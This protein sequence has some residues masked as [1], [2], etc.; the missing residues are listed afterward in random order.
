MPRGQRFWAGANAPFLAEKRQER[1]FMAKTAVFRA[2]TQE[3]GGA[4]ARSDSPEL[5][6]RLCDATRPLL[7]RVKGSKV[8]ISG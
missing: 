8:V 7:A 5:L 2:V 4:S 3:H 1:R 6:Y